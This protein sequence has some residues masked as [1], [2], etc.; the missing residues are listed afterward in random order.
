MPWSR[1]GAGESNS[2][3]VENFDGLYSYVLVLNRNHAE[4]Q[5]LVQE[6]C[7]RVLLA[8]GRLPAGNTKGWLFRILRNIWL[9][10]LREFR[11]GHQR[12]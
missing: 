5:D 10:Q 3:I 11:D 4:A 12:I 1:D 9:N 8:M 2:I 6:T 7:V